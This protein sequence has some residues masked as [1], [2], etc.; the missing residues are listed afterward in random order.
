MSIFFQVY[1]DI[2]I[3]GK[4]QGRIVI[5]LFGKTVPKTVKNFKTLAIGED[6]SLNVFIL[7]YIHFYH[8]FC[9]ICS[10]STEILKTA[11]LYMHL[12]VA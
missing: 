2:E 10:N 11:Y 12:K 7:K 5:G 4:A 3:G 8:S 9:L 6:V 1:F